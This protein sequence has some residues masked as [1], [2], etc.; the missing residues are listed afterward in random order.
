MAGAAALAEKHSSTSV[1]AANVRYFAWG[2]P[3]ALVTLSFIRT[4]FAKTFLTRIL[5]PI[6]DASYA[7]YLSHP[8]MMILFASLIK[9]RIL[10]PTGYPIV[11][12]LLLVIACTLFGLLV[13]YR[14]ERPLLAWLRERLS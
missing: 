5:G 4:E 2:L 14:V 12:P 6:G 7:I 10:K 13:H 9:L 3:A 11:W 8:S 1:L